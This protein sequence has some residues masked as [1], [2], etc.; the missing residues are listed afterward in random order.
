VEST[1]VATGYDDEALRRLADVKQA[2]DP[3]NVFRFNHDIT[4]SGPQ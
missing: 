2:W 3:D 4:P 1:G